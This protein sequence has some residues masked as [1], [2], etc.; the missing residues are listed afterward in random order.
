MELS[1]L[2]PLIGI[3]L[4]VAGFALKFNPLLVVTVAGLATGLA[5]GMDWPTLLATF[6]EK[7]LNSRQ[8][9]GT[10]LL[11]PVIGLLE[12]YGL[13]ER[14]QQWIAGIRS[15]TAGRVL[16]VYF[17]V[18]EI[19]ATLGLLSLGGHP[20]TVRPLLAPMAQGAARTLH[21]ELPPELEQR[22]AAHAAACENIALFFGEDVFI[23]FGA[24]LLM[25]A[26]LKENGITNVEPVT[27]GL[28]AIPTAVS[29]LIIHL[30]RLARLDASIARQI[31]A[32]QASRKDEL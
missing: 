6:G 21:G 4:V 11:L 12:R 29:A 23:A 14:A 2:L 28:W 8:L 27:I 31:H 19:S 16:M 22:I 9:S 7:F 3:P 18:R 5:V 20:Q 13:R 10:V 17:I 1:S 32:W 25:T 26:F 30:L 24:V 15:A